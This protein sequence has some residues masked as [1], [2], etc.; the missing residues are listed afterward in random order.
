MFLNYLLVYLF[1]SIFA[2]RKK[3]GGR[4]GSI[5]ILIKLNRKPS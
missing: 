4:A 5:G 2:L 1:F 3:H